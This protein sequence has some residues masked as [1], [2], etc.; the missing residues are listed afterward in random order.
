MP[1]PKLNLIFDIF[2]TLNILDQ[3]LTSSTHSIKESRVIK[4]NNYLEV[5]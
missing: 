5:G 1:K 3:I 2:F 4:Q